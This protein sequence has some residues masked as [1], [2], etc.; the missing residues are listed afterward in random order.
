MLSHNELM[1]ET[2]LTLY[3][4]NDCHLCEVAQALLNGLGHR[5]HIQNIDLDL[6]LIERYGSRV[7]VLVDTETQTEWDWPFSADSL[8]DRNS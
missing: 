4:R 8:K 2:S 6:G 1:A 5:Y 7:P 3:T